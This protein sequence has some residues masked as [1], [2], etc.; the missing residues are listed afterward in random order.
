MF[1]SARG[2][3]SGIDYMKN[4]VLANLRRSQSY[5]LSEHNDI[6]LESNEYIWKI[7]KEGKTT[8]CTSKK[9]YESKKKSKGKLF[10]NFKANDNGDT[11]Y[12]IL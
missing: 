2:T 8:Q 5:Q 12:Q 9:V 11:T 7:Y 1:S 10:K 6:K 3:Y 4:D